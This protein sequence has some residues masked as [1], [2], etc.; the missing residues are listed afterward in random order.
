[1]GTHETTYSVF[2]KTQHMPILDIALRSV[3]ARWTHRPQMFMHIFLKVSK[4]SKSQ[5]SHLTDDWSVALGQHMA[6]SAVHN[7]IFIRITYNILINTSRYTYHMHNNGTFHFHGV[8]WGGYM[9]HKGTASHACSPEDPSQVQTIQKPAASVWVMVSC[10]WGMGCGGAERVLLLWWTGLF[11][12]S[13]KKTVDNKI[14]LMINY[15]SFNRFCCTLSVF[16]LVFHLQSHFISG[17]LTWVALNCLVAFVETVIFSDCISWHRPLVCCVWDW[18]SESCGFISN[19]FVFDS[20]KQLKE[21][22]LTSKHPV[23]ISAHAQNVSFSGIILTHRNDEALCGASRGAKW[24][25]EGLAD[26]SLISLHTREDNSL[27]S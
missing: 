21:K 14:P 1:M 4:V 22:L 2:L 26:I 10:Y 23:C 18:Q 12:C 25:C 15:S 3:T 5:Y 7:D 27:M 8:L 6:T 9:S 24:S 11:S 19:S 13:G 16:W 17:D 20:E